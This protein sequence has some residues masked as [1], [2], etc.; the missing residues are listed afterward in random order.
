MYQFTDD[1]L[2][3]IEIIDNEHRQLFT[4]INAISDILTDEMRT[5]EE[6]LQS[7]KELLD[8][9]KEY[10]ATH[11]A[12][13]EEY[14]EEIHDPELERQKREHAEFTVKVNSV[15]LETRDASKGIRVFRDMMEYLSLWLYRHILAS[16]T[17]I[18]KIKVV[19]DNPVILTFSEKYCT[20]VELIDRE[21]RRLFEILADLNELNTDEFLSDKYDAIADVVEELKDYTVKHFQDE[22]R[23][24]QSIQYEGLTAQKNVH[25]SFIDKMDT[26]DLEEMDDKQQEYLNELIDFLA[27][28]LINHIMKMDQKIPAKDPEH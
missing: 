5:P 7:A 18:G 2:T 24:M 21:H 12:H 16:D 26:I 13:E 4:T 9:L 11:F 10:A 20:G 28:W 17:M 14:M 25:Q 23:Y 1:C 3:G 15:D 27:N 22:E 19:H 6:I 8:V